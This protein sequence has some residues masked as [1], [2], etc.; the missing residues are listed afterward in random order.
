MKVEQIISGAQTGADRAALD[1]AMEYGIE[2][3][4]WVP[5]GRTAEDG[6]LDERYQVWELPS[7]GYPERTEKNVVSADATLIL[8]HGELSGGSLLT[9]QLAQTHGKPWLHIDLGRA[10]AFDAAIDINDWISENGIQVL[11][12]AGPRA[13][14]DPTIYDRVYKILETVFYI[15]IISEVMP[16]RLEAGQGANDSEGASFTQP[17]SMEKA[18]EILIRE[19]PVKAKAQI[20]SM[21]P[22]RLS[23]AGASLAQWIHIHFGLADVNS[24]LLDDCRAR[25]GD[26]NLDREEAAKMI[27]RELSRQLAKM[28]HLRVVK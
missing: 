22:D 19:L 21:D 3:G 16:G 27:V 9:R 25:A 7:G 1:F 14:K 23:E 13:S 12:I 17:R 10:A 18:V 15:S 8:S 20:A 5:S 6:V 26:P 24:R 28:G 11:N 4:G 2:H